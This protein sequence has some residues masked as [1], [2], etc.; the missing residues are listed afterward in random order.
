MPRDENSNELQNVYENRN[1]N[2]SK[3]V[4][5]DHI[6][7]SLKIKEMAPEKKT[8]ER[9]LGES[10]QQLQ[11]RLLKVE[12]EN[13]CLKRQIEMVDKSLTKNF[14]L[15]ETKIKK[16]ITRELE[17]IPLTDKAQLL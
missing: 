7:D 8:L 17:E 14:T 12:K 5:K 2:I 4:I 13:V 9:K 3:D 16:P 10:K 6:Q 15:I 1:K 11:K